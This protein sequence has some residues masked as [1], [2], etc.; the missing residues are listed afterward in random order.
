[1]VWDL[2]T[3][4]NSCI[5]PVVATINRQSWPFIM[6]YCQLRSDIKLVKLLSMLGLMWIAKPMVSDNLDF[7]DR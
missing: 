2:E 4:N 7:Y 1:M 6:V 3:W 5:Q